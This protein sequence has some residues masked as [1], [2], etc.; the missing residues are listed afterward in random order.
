MQ[1]LP[2]VPTDVLC[3]T[4]LDPVDTVMAPWSF[5]DSLTKVHYSTVLVLADRR[6]VWFYS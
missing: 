6:R 2:T 3:H 5:V 1:E 4:H